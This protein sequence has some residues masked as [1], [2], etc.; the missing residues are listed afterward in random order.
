MS[1]KW[2]WKIFKWLKVEEI[3]SKNLNKI[4]IYLLD[5]K[6][7]LIHYFKM[8]ILLPE[9]CVFNFLKFLK[10]VFSKKKN[11]YI[12]YFYLFKMPYRHII[13]SVVLFRHVIFNIIS[14]CNI[15]PKKKSQC[16]IS[17]FLR[18]LIVIYTTWLINDLEEKERSEKIEKQVNTCKPYKCMYSLRS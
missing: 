6:T 9:T 4:L 17:F 12:F 8:K 10:V 16:N 15:F 3:F 11:I 13:L 7:Y 18:N 1:Q 5:S 14:Q 2:W